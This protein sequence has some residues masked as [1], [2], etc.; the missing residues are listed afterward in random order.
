LAAEKYFG[1]KSRKVL[2]SIC[3]TFYYNY[4]II[5]LNVTAKHTRSNMGEMSRALDLLMAFD[6]P[7]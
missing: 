1:Q 3:Y 4:W 5:D 6:T 7:Y 2:F